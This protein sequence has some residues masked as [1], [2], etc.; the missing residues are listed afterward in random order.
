[1]PRPQLQ[2]SPIMV[3][4]KT[5]VV[6]WLKVNTDGSVRGTNI[7]AA[8]GGIF[9]DFSACFR[10]CFA[11]NLG[12][13]SVL[14]AEIMVIILAM[15]LAHSFGWFHLWVESDSKL[16]LSAFEN[17]SIVPWDLRNRWSNCLALGLNINLLEEY[18]L[19]SKD[20]PSAKVADQDYL[21]LV[22]SPNHLSQVSTFSMPESTYLPDLSNGARVCKDL[23]T[24]AMMLGFA[25]PFNPSNDA[26]ICLSLQSKQDA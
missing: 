4:W 19:I 8:C 13:V 21:I 3:L 6:P 18:L 23:L 26:R 17:S 5:L 25:Y 14:H 12:V 24:R 1:M 22:E 7:A 2:H 15:E 11:C 20:Q 9:Q 10:G 16:A